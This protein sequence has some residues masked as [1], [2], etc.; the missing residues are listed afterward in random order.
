MDCVRR[1][2]LAGGLGVGCDG[3]GFP[4]THGDHPP[5]HPRGHSCSGAAT[6]AFLERGRLDQ[7]VVARPSGYDRGIAPVTGLPGGASGS[8]RTHAF[9]SMGTRVRLI[10]PEHH[11]F[12]EAIEVVKEIFVRLNDRFT[13][14]RNDSELSRVNATAGAW[15]PVSTEFAGLLSTSLAAAEETDGLFDPTIL[16][17]LLSAGYDRDFDEI[18]AGAR[19]ALNPPTPCGRWRDVILV[20]ERLRLPSGVA[21]DFGGIAKG[22]AADL[23]AEAAARHLPW[24][25]MDAGGDLRLAGAEPQRPGLEIAV[26][27]PGDPNLEMLRLRLEEGALATSSVTARSWGPGRHHL[28]DPRTGS[29]ADTGVLQATVWA[30]TCTQAEVGS[31]L[32]LMTGEPILARL[33]A[34]I[35]LTDGRVLVSMPGDVGAPAWADAM[36]Q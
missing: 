22:W 8:I 14:F 29:P 21:L 31:K 12:D 11:R 4:P 24:A 27:D 34:I 13:R 17:A 20:D 1:G 28:I 35:V 33:P 3:S 15:T 16:P 19:L 7:R 6:R 23:A 10:G 32:A 9:R 2:P 30:P 25:L 26:E 36:P 18:I 5:R